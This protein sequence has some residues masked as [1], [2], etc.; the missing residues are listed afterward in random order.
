MEHRQLVGTPLPAEYLDFAE[1]PR[2]LRLGTLAELTRGSDGGFADAVGG[3]DGAN[4]EASF[5]PP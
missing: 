1:P 4:G 5:G 2:L 3:S